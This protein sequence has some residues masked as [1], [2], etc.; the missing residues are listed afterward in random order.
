MVFFKEKGV[1]MICVTGQWMCLCDPMRFYLKTIFVPPL[2]DQTVPFL[3]IISPA[4]ENTRSHG[5]D[6]GVHKNVCASTYRLGYIFLCV[7]QY[8]YEFSDL[9]MFGSAK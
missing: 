1:K 2:L 7:A 8:S 3:E 5:T 6:D 9:G 4:F